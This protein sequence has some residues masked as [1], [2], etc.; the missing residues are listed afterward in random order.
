VTGAGL[1]SEAYGAGDLAVGKGPGLWRRG[2]GEGEEQGNEM[3][4]AFWPVPRAQN[5]PQMNADEYG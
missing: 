4:I 1:G 3:K 5:W 2:T